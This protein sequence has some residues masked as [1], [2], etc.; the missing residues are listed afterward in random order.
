MLPDRKLRLWFATCYLVSPPRAWIGQ[1]QLRAGWGLRNS[2]VLT[3]PT[4]ALGQGLPGPTV[5]GPTVT[6]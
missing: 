4:E 2:N 3:E 6:T 1:E 5:L